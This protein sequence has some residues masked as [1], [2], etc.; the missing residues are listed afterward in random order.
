[1][2]SISQVG[3]LGKVIGIDMR[4]ERDAT[5]SKGEFHGMS[6]SM[7]ANENLERPNL[8]IRTVDKAL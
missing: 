7:Y 2:S 4:G 8:K 5:I 6:H 3:K 1:M